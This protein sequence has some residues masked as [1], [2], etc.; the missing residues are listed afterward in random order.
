MLIF[1]F[2]LLFLIIISRKTQQ[3]AVLSDFVC[4]LFRCCF[5]FDTPEGLSFLWVWVFE[6]PD[7]LSFLW[8]WGLGFRDTLQKC[9]N[10][11]SKKIFNSVYKLYCSDAFTSKKRTC[12][13]V[14]KSGSKGKSPVELHRITNK[15][16]DIDVNVYYS[17]DAA[18]QYAL[19]S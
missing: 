5:F 12:V 3:L 11:N 17:W 16:L 19:N 15:A 10:C 4:V 2:F 18:V 8:V 9:V 6:T 1:L 7:D 13:H 14:L